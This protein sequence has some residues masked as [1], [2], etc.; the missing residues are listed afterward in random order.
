MRA[1]V[2]GFGVCVLCLFC[3]AVHNVLSSFA[4]IIVANSVKRHVCD[5][6]DSTLA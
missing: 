3:D 1:C 4:I 5:V 2:H 6:Q